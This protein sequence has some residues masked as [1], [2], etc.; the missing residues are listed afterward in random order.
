MNSTN[1]HSDEFQR[2]INDYYWLLNKKYPQKGVLK[3]VG[4]RYSLDRDQRMVLY[5]GICSENEAEQRQSKLV[6]KIENKHLYVDGYNVL[7]TLLNYRLGKVL[8]IGN[9]NYLRDV[10][11]IYGRIKNKDLFYEC[12]NWFIE[13]LSNKNLREVIIYLDEPVSHSGKHKALLLTKMSE[14]NIKGA[15][16]VVPSADFPLKNI[17]DGIIASSDSVIIDHA[18]NAYDLSRAILECRFS[19]S[20]I[21]FSSNQG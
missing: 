2:A 6:G 18:E 16:H 17:R 7:Y 20:F 13:F 14:F 1:L 9:D 19:C 10:G 12:V 21:N 3:L 5:R 11:G 4:D 15:C 8:F